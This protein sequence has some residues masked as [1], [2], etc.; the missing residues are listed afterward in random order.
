MTRFQPRK[1]TAAVRYLPTTEAYDRW[2]SVYD[3]DGNFLV[4]LDTQELRTLF[5]RFVSEIST[6][7][8]WRLVDLGCGTGRN[9]G[10]I[11]ETGGVG[12]VVA[13]DASSGMLQR[14]RDR[15]GTATGRDG[16]PAVAFEL[17]DLIND[18]QPP[19]AVLEADAVVST[20]VLEHIPC[21][22]YFA[23][24]AKMLKPGGVL[25]LTNM[26]AD[27]GKISQA[28]FVDPATGEKIRPTSYA[29]TVERL[30]KAAEAHGLEPIG[31]MEERKV[32]E[33]MV[34]SLGPRSRKWIGVYC[35][36]GVLFRKP[37]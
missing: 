35:W 10:L 19:T 17:F 2:A 8:P 20:L 6:A 5:P 37:R 32:D 1:T 27:M 9:T 25:L 12:E 7:P 24:V 16:G 23:Q 34:D 22:V 14:A 13:V 28:G 21:D 29:H 11:A 36:L 3:T 15:L 33:S 26:H 31:E 18:A 4:S 30:K